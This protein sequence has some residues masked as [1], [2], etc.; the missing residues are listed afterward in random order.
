MFKVDFVELTKDVAEGKEFKLE[1]AIREA[2]NEAAGRELPLNITFDKARTTSN[3]VMQSLRGLDYL[4]KPVRFTEEFL[5]AFFEEFISSFRKN[6]N[7]EVN[8]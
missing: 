5:V 3:I 7:A 6:Y 1:M 4:N 2:M 8:K